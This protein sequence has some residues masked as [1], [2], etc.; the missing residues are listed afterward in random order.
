MTNCS[1]NVWMKEMQ[2]S[3]DYAEQRAEVVITRRARPVHPVVTRIVENLA[4]IEAV[5]I[6]RVTPGSL[7]APSE[8]WEKGIRS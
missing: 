5:R 1:R 8:T 3:R 7:S 4:E 6:V 2:T